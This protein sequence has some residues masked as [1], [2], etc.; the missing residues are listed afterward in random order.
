MT[1]DAV[2]FGL[3]I[4]HRSHGVL[5]LTE[6]SPTTGS[7]EVM[8]GVTDHLAE[9][10]AMEF[11]GDTSLVTSGTI[12][13]GEIFEAAAA[14]GIPT[15]RRPRGRYR[16]DLPTAPQA[17]ASIGQLVAAGDV[18]VVPAEPVA[19]GDTVRVGWWA[20]D[21]ATGE[22][23]DTMDD[24]SASEFAEDRP[25]RPHQDDGLVRCYG[26]LGAQVAAL[27]VAATTQVRVI[28]LMTNWSPQAGRAGACVFV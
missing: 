19:I 16:A 20:I 22:T 13:V 2:R 21:P 18:V 9:R 4:W 5:P 25:H 6:G 24:G 26:A 28:E 27:I 17:T 23:T 10:F 14:Q 1:C 15:L 12:G 7:A 11:A 3:D 8:A